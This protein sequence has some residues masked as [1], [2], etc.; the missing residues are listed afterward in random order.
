MRN[1]AKKLARSDLARADHENWAAKGGG[2]P[3]DADLA[4]RW[5]LHRKL[6]LLV[7]GLEPL[8]RR[9]VL[10]RFFE[11][12]SSAEIARRDGVPLATI[13]TRLRRGMERLR[14]SLE[15]G[16]P[17][18]WRQALVPLLSRGAP[19][20]P[21][22]VLV[23][24]TKNV[25]VVVTAVVALVLGFVW[26]GSALE[27]TS[28]P[29]GSRRD[30]PVHTVGHNVTGEPA[31]LVGVGNGGASPQAEAYERRPGTAEVGGP[32]HA[33]DLLTGLVTGPVGAPL[34]EAT[35]SVRH[36][37]TG[38]RNSLDLLENA[39]TRAIG[40]AQ[41]DADGLF[42][43]R[44]PAHLPLEVTVRAPSYAQ[45][46]FTDAFGGEHLV[47]E[48]GS[49]SVLEGRVLDAETGLGL[50][51]I[52]LRGWMMQPRITDLIKGTTDRSGGFRFDDLPPG[53]LT[54]AVEPVILA[55]P[56]WRHIRLEAGGL[57]RLEVVLE[58]GVTVS[59]VV[60]NAETGLPIRGAEVG[61]GWTFDRSVRTDEEGR[62][63]LHGF[64]GPG[65]YDIHARADGHG[66]QQHE[67]D[68]E[69]MPEADTT[70][71]FALPSGH[72]AVGRV[73]GPDSS[74]VEG[75]YVAAVASQRCDDVQRT[76]WDATHTDIDGRFRL[77]SLT[78]D[79]RHKLLVRSSGLG[80]VVYD[81]PPAETSLAETDLGTIQLGLGGRLVGMVVDE[82]G[83]P[84]PGLPVTVKGH[85]TDAGRYLPEGLSPRDL[86]HTD[87]VRSKTDSRGRFHFADLAGGTYELQAR[88]LGRPTNP[89]LTVILADGERREDLVLVAPLGMTLR[90]VV[91][92]HLGAPC[93]GVSVRAYAEQGRRES[94]RADTDGDGAFF[95]L[96]LGPGRYRIRVDTSFFNRDERETRE[97]CSQE[98]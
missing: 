64:G 3:S 34:A 7:M 1:A 61:A 69:A 16:T 57:V 27:N 26:L 94:A 13:R 31:G 53:E 21:T 68:W 93:A 98:V 84:R 82:R 9:V 29:A 20:T 46:R 50:P 80:R 30:L 10:L 6:V 81:F 4:E 56:A 15:R 65:V 96:G 76:D 45:A 8:Y 86:Y 88:E 2:D 70:L 40:T 54:F 58:P 11:G 87:Q 55:A 43:V 5:D 35:V 62:Y 33:D 73:I 83:E 97:L 23:V 91:I 19:T 49:G 48:L 67:F 72:V 63:A 66:K 38:G 78:P 39:K 59:G 89:K 12:L 14:R 71:D 77:S 44:V 47:V 41:C 92:D 37:P 51:G 25:L 22:G 36:R 28:S 32:P 85:A 90:G 74:P 24:G 52:S 17:G 18:D 42:Q 95:L 60:T 75:A 79:L